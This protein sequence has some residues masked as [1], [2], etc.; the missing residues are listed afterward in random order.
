MSRKTEKA[1]MVSAL[2]GGVSRCR[3]PGRIFG[4]DWALA[5]LFAHDVPGGPMNL[6]VNP[7]DGGAGRTTLIS[8]G[9][10]PRRPVTRT[11]TSY[12]VDR[13]DQRYTFGSSARS[14]AGDVHR[15]IVDSGLKARMKPA[16]S[17]GCS[18]LTPA[19]TGPVSRDVSTLRTKAISAPAQVNLDWTPPRPRRRA[20]LRL[21]SRWS[22]AWR[23]RRRPTIARYCIAVAATLKTGTL[24]ATLL[25]PVAAKLDR[26]HASNDSRV[27][28]R[29]HPLLPALL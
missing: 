19:G 12:R 10:G 3:R 27:H 16:I 25:T 15:C 13:F 5:A 26:P 28:G 8:V 11:I 23:Q 7:A 9:L 21:T 4:D 29:C 24:C 17:T 18:P 20:R 2:G 1:D 14:T 6:T 22:D